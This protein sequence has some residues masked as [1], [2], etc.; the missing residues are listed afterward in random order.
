MNKIQI[1]EKIDKNRN[2]INR[3]LSMEDTQ[4]MYYTVRRLAKENEKLIAKLKK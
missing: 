2:L 1:Q 3:A 4:M